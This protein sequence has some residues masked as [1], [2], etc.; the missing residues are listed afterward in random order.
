MEVRPVG[1]VLELK[2]KTKEKEDDFSE[3]EKLTFEEITER[4]KKNADR[5]KQE[6]LQQNKQVLRDYR[7]KH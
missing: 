4:N 6:R 1:V 5:V 2:R 7:I 3:T